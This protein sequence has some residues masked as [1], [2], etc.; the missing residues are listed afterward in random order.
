[1]SKGQDLECLKGVVF[2]LTDLMRLEVIQSHLHSA[3]PIHVGIGMRQ[4]YLVRIRTEGAS[5]ALQC[6]KCWAQSPY[7][8]WTGGDTD[9]KDNGVTHT[10]RL[11]QPRD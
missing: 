7:T 8:L 3:L 4:S 2:Q 6:N 1:M 5:E 10:G 9:D 11:Y